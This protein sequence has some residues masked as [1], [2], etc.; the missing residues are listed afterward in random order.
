MQK[1]SLIQWQVDGLQ[2]PWLMTPK[3]T[4][5]SMMSTPK[6][7]SSDMSLGS[8][9]GLLNMSL[10]SISDNYTWLQSE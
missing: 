4:H 9:L 6:E 5:K 2:T 7:I 1:D 10:P 3:G 8:V